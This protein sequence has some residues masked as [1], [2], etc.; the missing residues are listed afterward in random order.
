MLTIPLIIANT[1]T[2]SDLYDVADLLGTNQE[3]EDYV[4]AGVITPAGLEATAISLL[5]GTAQNAPKL[6][7]DG[8]GAEVAWT[9]GA[10]EFVRIRPSDAPFLPPFV[11][12]SLGTAV[13]NEAGRTVHLILAKR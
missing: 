11:G 3:V 5:F 7:K 9:V 1:E 13:S 2:D 8:D 10:D 4:I 6:F 12:V